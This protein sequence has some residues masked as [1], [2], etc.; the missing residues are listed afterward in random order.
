MTILRAMKPAMSPKTI[1]EDID[2]LISSSYASR[3]I[4]GKLAFGRFWSVDGDLDAAIL[5]PTEGGIIGR[6]GRTVAH[7]RGRKPV[8]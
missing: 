6:D 4:P 7:S 2:I 1:Q 5:L 8:W 3:A